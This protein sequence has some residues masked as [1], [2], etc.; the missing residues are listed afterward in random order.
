MSFLEIPLS[1]GWAFKDGED[2]NEGWMP[3]PVVPSVVH[4]D[5]MANKK[6]ATKLLV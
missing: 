4:Q 6:S 1:T 2:D 3:V 5:L